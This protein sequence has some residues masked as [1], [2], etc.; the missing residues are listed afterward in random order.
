MGFPCVANLPQL[1]GLSYGE[2]FHNATSLLLEFISGGSA[3]DEDHNRNIHSYL[4]CLSDYTS[5]VEHAVMAAQA[6]RELLRRS[7]NAVR[8]L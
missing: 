4:Q 8:S 2:L 5:S 7:R 6:L 3:A 1:F